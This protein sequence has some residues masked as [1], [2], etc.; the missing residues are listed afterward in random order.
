MENY[1]NYFI[2]ADAIR[3]GSTTIPIYV[4]DITDENI[5]DHID[6]IFAILKDGIETDYVH[7][8][9]INISWGGDVNCDLFIVDYWFSLFMWKMILTNHEPIKP[10]HIFYSAEL[11]RKNIKNFVDKFVLT[12]ENKIKFGNEYLNNNICDGL[13]AY[14]FIEYFSYY[15]ACT[16]NNEDNI[17]LMNASPE[18]YALLHNSMQGIA[19]EDVKNMGLELTDKAI[20]IIKDSKKYI[21]YDHG[22][23][24]SFKASEAINPRQFK[25]AILNIGTKP[26]GTGGIYPYVIDSNFQNG[27]INDPL[28]Y[29]IES[30]SARTAQILSKNNVGESGDFARLLGLNNTDTILNKDPNFECLSRNFIKFEIKSDKHL[31]MIKNRYYRFNP[32]GM[33]HVIDDNDKSLVGQTIYLRSPMTCSC[34]KSVCRRCYGDLYYTNINI[35]IGK[36]AAE[37][38]SSQ[39]TQTLLSAKH[40]LETKIQAIKWNPEFADYFDIDINA[41]K[42]TDLDSLNLSKYFLVIDPND[43]YLE[44][45]EED[46]ISLDDDGNEIVLDDDIDIYNEYIPHF[47]IKTPTGEEIKF[48][49]E[50]GDN[51]LYIS[52]ELNSIIRKKAIPD[53]G[54]AIIPLSALT[55]IILFYVKIINNEISKTMNDIINIINKSSVTENLTKD[56]AMQNIVDLIIDGNLSIDAV[57]LE[58]ILANQI[59]NA[60]DILKKPNWNTPN[61]SYKLFSLD[62]ALMNN[63]SVVITLL[64]QNLG[65]VLYTPLTYSKHS[66]SFFDLFFMEQPQNYMNADLLDTEPVIDSPEKGITMVKIVD[67]DKK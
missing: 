3:N 1:K 25:E 50:N 20:S 32:N 26:N 28:S 16:I 4:P 14:S 63:P 62:H 60:D 39:L 9:K 17:E 23:S 56:Q 22:L 29:F 31:S 12:K 64:Y 41:I 65:K 44:N 15:L 55:D 24:A 51:S 2:Y 18:F 7:N 19:F 61:A 57:H 36:I 27:G 8:L 21:G 5:D 67:K 35:N 13:W 34:G 11:K 30:S 59:V 48:G 40:L 45:E 52:K 38:L 49:S 33:E 54:K 46:S 66:P 10:K 53:D 58:V 43:I 37:I 42:L 6:G 47:Y